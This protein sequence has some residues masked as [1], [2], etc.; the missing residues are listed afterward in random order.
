MAGFASHIVTPDQLHAVFPLVREAVPGLTLRAWVA[1][2]R[3]LATPRRA[4]QAGIV[5][6]RRVPRP[7]PCGLFLYRRETDLAHGPILATEYFVAVDVLDPA[8]VVRALIEEMDGLA[9]R[10][11]CTGIRALV[12]D[13]NAAVQAGL[14]GAGLR[15]DGA[16]LW[17]RLLPIVPAGAAA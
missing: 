3:P 16:T 12:R 6:V 8:P 1:F 2:A 11:G 15:A 17:K 5:A 4:A 9:R 14:R 10:F 7:L 13:R